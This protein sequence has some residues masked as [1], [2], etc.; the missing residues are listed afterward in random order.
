MCIST[1]VS[2]GFLSHSFCDAK[3]VKIVSEA[4]PEM[5]PMRQILHI[6][7]SK[8]TQAS[9]VYNVRERDKETRT[10]GTKRYER[11]PT[12]KLVPVDQV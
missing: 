12:E 4:Q 6:F 11:G 3:A 7:V 5:C 2:T 1:H 9:R 10:C 8:K